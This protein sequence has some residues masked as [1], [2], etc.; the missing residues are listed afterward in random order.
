MRPLILSAALFSLFFLIF[1]ITEAEE[2]D[3]AFTTEPKKDIGTLDEITGVFYVNKPTDSTLKTQN[4]TIALFKS[5]FVPGWGQIGNK[6]YIKAGVII[7]LEVILAGTIYHYTQKT[8]DARENFL[9]A[10]DNNQAR[11]FND[12]MDAKSERN[13]FGWFLGTTIF[14]SMFDAFVDAHLAKFPKYDKKI[15]VDVMPT[16]NRTLG[17]KLSIRL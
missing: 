7:S 8:S 2:P 16:E 13:R 11:L 5:M 14:L 17:L 1:P 12:F 4:P 3:S 15:S 9:N 10:D 6:R